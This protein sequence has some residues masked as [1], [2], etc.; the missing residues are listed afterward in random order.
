MCSIAT[1]CSVDADRGSG[2][3]VGNIV[4]DFRR[5][6]TLFAGFLIGIHIAVFLHELGHALG[7][8]IGGGHVSAI[9][10]LAPLPAGYVTGS[11]PNPLPSIWGGVAFGSLCTLAPLLAAR[12]L[13]A[14]SPVRFAALMTAAFCLGHNAIYLFVGS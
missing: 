4:N 3:L 2:T 7:T 6:L 14:K 10:M 12:C 11:A 5:T 13:D 8:W 9:V 1:Q